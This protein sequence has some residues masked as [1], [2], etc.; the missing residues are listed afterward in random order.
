[1]FN[2]DLLNWHLLGVVMVDWPI[3][4]IDNGQT[5]RIEFQTRKNVLAHERKV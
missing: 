3:I 2:S 5:W 1:M 4:T